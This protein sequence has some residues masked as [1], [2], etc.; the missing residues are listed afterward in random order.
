MS[1]TFTQK[2][3]VLRDRFRF[4]TFWSCDV[5]WTAFFN[6]TVGTGFTAEQ[7]TVDDFA[8]YC[9]GY[10]YVLVRRVNKPQFEETSLEIRAI[11]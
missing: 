7:F 5:I 9:L 4:L 8:C 3:C 11:P 6:S 2:Y 10:C 1:V